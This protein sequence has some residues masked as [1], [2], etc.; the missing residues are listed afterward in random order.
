[1]AKVWPDVV[2]EETNLTKNILLLR[3]ALGN[4][5]ESAEFIQT[6]PKIGYRFIAPF[7]L[8]EDTTTVP[9]LASLGERD[10]ERPEAD[11]V[12]L[13]NTD[14][15]SRPQ[16]SGRLQR[17]YLPFAALLLVMVAAGCWLLWPRREQ[18]VAALIES[19]RNPES[20]QVYLKGRML[21][22]RRTAEGFLQGVEYLNQA[23][24][25]DSRNALA[26]TSLS[27]CYQLM[28]EGAGYSM[29]EMYQRA[30]TMALK[31][32]EVD[33]DSAEAQAQL[34]FLELTQWYV[35]S[36]E[37]RMKR[38]VELNPDLAETPAR[39]SIVLLA[40]GRFEEALAEARRSQELDP[41]STQAAVCQSVSNAAQASSLASPATRDVARRRRRIF[42]LC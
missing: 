3:K 41:S 42:R 33:E 24:E 7:R 26:W 4:G 9:P 32:V 14:H 38:A 13:S 11:P 27:R 17:K 19:R 1:M 8:V 36:A 5:S 39:Y 23:V 29:A 12:P 25:K 35:A 22:E 16:T 6:I 28:A 40:Q 2:V 37:R 34:G 10:G 18:S 31:A 20:H 30:T 15:P 21:C